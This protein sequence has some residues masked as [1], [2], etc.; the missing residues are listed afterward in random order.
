[1]LLSS[2]DALTIALKNSL[3]VKSVGAPILNKITLEY[4]VAP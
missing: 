3:G 2:L 1:M 4:L